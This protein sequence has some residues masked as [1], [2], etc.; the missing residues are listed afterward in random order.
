MRPYKKH[1][2]KNYFLH[3][4]N[5]EMR[6]K[7]RKRLLNWQLIEKTQDISFMEYKKTMHKKGDNAMH[8]V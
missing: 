2:K 6:K 7:N 1:K 3:N 8:M 4:N 5:M